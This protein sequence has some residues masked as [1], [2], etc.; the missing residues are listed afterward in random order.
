MRPLTEAATTLARLVRAHASGTTTTS[1]S[2]DRAAASAIGYW[3]PGDSVRV[4]HA[5]AEFYATL[6]QNIASARR[7]I[8][9]SALY[10]GQGETDLISTLHDALTA[11]PNT[12]LTILIDCLR[13]T[14]GADTNS[15]TAL[16]PLLDAF[17]HRV[18]LSL[19]HTPELHGWK[20]KLVPPRFN[21]T[22]GLLHFKLFATDDTLIISGANLSHD[23]FTN[24]QDRYMQIADARVTQHYVRLVDAVADLSYRVTAGAAGSQTTIT[25][26]TP[27]PVDAPAAYKRHARAK[28]IPTLTVPPHDTP[29]P[30]DPSL[31]TLIVPAFQASP[32]G[33]HQDQEYMAGLWAGLRRR[34]PPPT[35]DHPPPPPALPWSLYFTSGYFNMTRP[36]ASAM[37]ATGAAATHILTASPAANGFFGSR[38]VSRHLPNAYTWLAVR[39]LR[40]TEDHQKR[41][42]QDS[43]SGDSKCGNVV[44]SEY[45]RPDW[46]FHAK[47]LW[48]HATFSSSSKTE[49][50]TDSNALSPPELLLPAVS[51]VGSSNFG[52][53]STHR[54]LE[55]QAYVLTTNPALRRSLQREID[56]LWR[57]AR[58]VSVA[59]LES[60]NVPWATKLAAWVV[61]NML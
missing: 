49:S 15:V 32:L 8:V 21:E 44:L 35:T 31:D 39:F 7:R 22:I 53:R 43:N 33:I 16:A 6:K 61:K 17:P 28:L 52:H 41:Q 40:H 42:I 56:E 3:V 45:E 19:Y 24:R 30:K 51:V 47:G 26:P 13:G 58:R 25:A 9:L 5:P 2:A 27:S 11:N 50:A 10:I 34:S 46:T 12:K 36:V 20:K 23:Y 14:R 37:L 54:D 18:T 4:M 55:A 38:G 60:R 59:E 1:T 29:K 57:H 48:V